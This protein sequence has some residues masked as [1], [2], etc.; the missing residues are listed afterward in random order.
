MKFFLILFLAPVLALADVESDFSDL[1]G[2]KI[3]LEKAKALNPEMEVSIVQGRTVSRRNRWE[4]S[5]ESSGSFGGDTYV[6]TLNAGLNIHYHINPRW[7]LGV[8]YNRSFNKLSAEGNALIEQAIAEYEKDPSAPKVLIPE[9]DFPKETQMA[10]IN[11]YPIYGKMNL[12]DK[13]IAQ[14]DVYALLGYGKVKL[15]SGVQTAYSAGGGFGI[16]WTKKISTRLEMR[17]EGFKAQYLKGERPMDLGLAS[18]QM[19]WML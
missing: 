10:F 8:K 14:F 12:L 7:S 16:W 5:A 4:L 6:K 15:N 2:N 18:V 11:W 3:I 13:G 9:I 19:G 17:W 1:G